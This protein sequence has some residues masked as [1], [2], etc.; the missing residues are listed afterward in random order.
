MT[1]A[2]AQRVLVVEDEMLVAMLI[3]DMLAELGHTV[4]GPVTRLEDGLRFARS[5]DLDFA[6]LDLNLNGQP[7]TPIARVLQDRGI[8]FVFASGY[9]SGGLEGE[10]RSHPM[11]KKPFNQ[12][13]LSSALAR[14]LGQR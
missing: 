2:K 3:E 11:L 5:A 1:D 8:P 12:D 10:F 9:G 4:V 13:H 6:L 14:L 7:S